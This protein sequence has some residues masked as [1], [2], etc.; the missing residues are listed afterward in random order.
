[1]SRNTVIQLVALLGVGCPLIATGQTTCPTVGQIA[2]RNGQP[3]AG[4][5]NGANVTI[6]VVG[7][8]LQTADAM[9][10]A[11]GDEWSTVLGATFTFT[12]TNVDSVQSGTATANNPVIIFQQGPASDFAPGA[13]CAGAF[14]CTQPSE[15]DPSGHVV[16]G[17]IELNPANTTSNGFFQEGFDHELGHSAFGLG[18]LRRMHSKP[19][20]HGESGH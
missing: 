16:I 9:I 17:Q 5:Q 7:T 13:G 20:D 8:S 1:M 15:I 11:A 14:L 10:Q 4:L 18:G 2:G 19:N 3:N 12:V 6:E